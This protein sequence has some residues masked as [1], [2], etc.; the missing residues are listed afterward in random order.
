MSNIVSYYC[1]TVYLSIQNNWNG[2]ER[3]RKRSVDL[4]ILNCLEKAVSKLG[5]F[6]D[7]FFVGKWCKHMRVILNIFWK[8]LWRNAL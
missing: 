8:Q 4:Q 3:V 7:D 5:V 1:E 6:R 2:M